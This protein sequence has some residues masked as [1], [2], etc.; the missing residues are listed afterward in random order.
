MQTDDSKLYA[1]FQAATFAA[2]AGGASQGA[3]GVSA[4]SAVVNG[5]TQP[6]LANGNGTADFEA[7]KRSFEG[8]GAVPNG[9][10]SSGPSN[11]AAGVNGV[12]YPTAGFVQPN[13]LYSGAFGGAPAGG[14]QF[15]P[16]GST[17][18][19]GPSGLVNGGAPSN[20]QQ[21]GSFSGATSP[22]HNGAL[23]AN[24]GS[25][26][27]NGSI[28]YASPVAG[29]ATLPGLHGAPNGFSAQPYAGSA[30]DPMPTSPNPYGGPAAAP[31]SPQAGFG[32]LG[33]GSPYMGMMSP[34]LGMN[35]PQMGGGGFGMQYPIG[36]NGHNGFGSP[37]MNATQTPTVRFLLFFLPSSSY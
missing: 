13:G 15:V 17:N 20:G 34:M 9:V 22:Y 36:G 3:P 4:P 31:Y 2:A 26:G 8:A 32:G 37:S 35:S 19:G 12:P 23:S 18:G 1:P 14:A 11:G 30:F 25:P 33:I 27:P 10:V 21:N 24:G 16:Q 29:A 6:D 7:M 5:A 28:P